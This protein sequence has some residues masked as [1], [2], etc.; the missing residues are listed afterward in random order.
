MSTGDVIFMVIVVG[1]AILVAILKDKVPAWLGF[2]A[3][4]AA[5]AVAI[6]GGAVTGEFKAIPLGVAGVVGT[7]IAWVAGARSSVE[8]NDDTLGGAAK[9]ISL[10][11]WLLI[12]LVVCGAVAATLAIPETPAK[13]AKA[14]IESQR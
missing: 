2:V 5:G 4:L 7:I 8:A 3:M 10:V 1:V 9:N 14:V 12:A 6:V 13:S 11:P